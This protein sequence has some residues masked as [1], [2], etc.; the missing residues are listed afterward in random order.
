MKECGSCLFPVGS[1]FP[2]LILETCLG[3]GIYV[4]EEN[5]RLGGCG[6]KLMQSIETAVIL[7]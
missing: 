6:E 2:T 7:K 4:V 3:D 5:A 1:I